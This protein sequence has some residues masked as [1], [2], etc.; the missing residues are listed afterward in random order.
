VE[1]APSTVWRI[2][3]TDDNPTMWRSLSDP[4]CN[5]IQFGVQQSIQ[6]KTIEG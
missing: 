6:T 2:R 1:A 5:V 4:P 3:A